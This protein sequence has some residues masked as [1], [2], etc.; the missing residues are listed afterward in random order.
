MTGVLITSLR[1]FG[2]TES[3]GFRSNSQSFLPVV[4]F[5]AAHPPVAL[6]DHDLHDVAD[7]ADG[8]RRPLSVQD[9]LA[10]GVVLPHEFAGRL[11]DRDDR[12]RLR[13]R[14]VDVAFVLAVRRA[15]EDQILVRRPA[16]SSPGCAGATPSSSIMSKRQMTSASVSRGQLL[17]LDGTVVRCRR[18]SRRCRRPSARR[19]STR[20]TPCRSR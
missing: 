8:R 20:N 9:L 10:D 3:F 2:Q 14:D 11:V 7:L 17:V 6:A 18:G 16:T 1:V 15:D 4:R 12:R 5:V 13:R 19:G